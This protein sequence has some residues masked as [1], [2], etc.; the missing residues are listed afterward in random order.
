MKISANF[1]LAFWQ[2]HGVDLT[3][4]PNPNKGNFSYRINEPVNG[5]AQ[6]LIRSMDGRLAYSHQI[7]TI[8]TSYVGNV[9]CTLTPGMYYLEIDTD[10]GR[11]IKKFL[12]R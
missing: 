11:L 12:V 1:N 6:A 10:K 3:I 9:A 8:G 4:V 2:N 7:G 5:A